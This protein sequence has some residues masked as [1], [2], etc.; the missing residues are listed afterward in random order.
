MG[1]SGSDTAIETA[2]IALMNDKAFSSPLSR[3]S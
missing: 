2:N 3:S 1:T